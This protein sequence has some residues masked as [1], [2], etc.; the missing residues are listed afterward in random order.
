MGLDVEE[1]SLSTTIDTRLF[2]RVHEGWHI[3]TKLTGEE[4]TDDETT[5]TEKDSVYIG[6]SNSFFEWIL[7]LS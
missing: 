7:A 5:T 2:V 1:D 4:M 3:W 6:Q